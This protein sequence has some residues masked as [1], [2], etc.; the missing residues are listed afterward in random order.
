MINGYNTVML[1]L[2][3][4]FNHEILQRKYRKMTILKSFSPNS[5]VKLSLHYT[6]HFLFL[7]TLTPNTVMLWLPNSL[8]P[9]ILQRNYR[10]M[11]ILRSFSYNSFVKLSLY[12]TVHYNLVH[13]ILWS[14]S[15][16][17]FVKL[18]LYNTV[19]YNLVHCYVLQT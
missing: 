3:N 15:Y 12:N 5:F 17:S 16:N 8:N 19:H 1:W 6:V 4:S 11:T 2:P 14:F 18:S 10:K 7:C 9:E 13:S